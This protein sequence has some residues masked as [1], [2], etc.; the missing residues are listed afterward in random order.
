MLKLVAVPVPDLSGKSI[1][2]TGA[3]RGIGAELVRVLAGR[4]ARVFAGVNLRDEA[5]TLP[6]AVTVLPLNVTSDASVAAAFARVERDAGKLDALVNNA[7]VVDPIGPLPKIS[8]DGLSRALSINVVGA[9]R[10]TLAALRLLRAS[11]GVIVNA[12]TG[13]ATTP[14]E[15]WTTYCS[16]K[17]ALLMLS[18][19]MALELAANSIRVYFLGIPPTDTAMQASIR[20]S[21]L[22]PIS[23]IPQADLA[24]CVVPASCMAW[25]CSDA[26]KGLTEVLLDVR[27]EP[28]ATMMAGEVSRDH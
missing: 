1:L 19:M 12:G 11:S 4:G 22:N 9:H 2:V 13:A 26:S 17:A 7:G 24:P 25:L 28:F 8:C 18:R 14:L 3:G 20:K 6:A 27:R 21:G 23:Q 5:E 15:G 16:S 10:V